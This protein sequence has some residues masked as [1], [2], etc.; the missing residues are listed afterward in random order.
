MELSLFYFC[1]TEEVFAFSSETKQLLMFMGPRP[2]ANRDHLIAFL[3]NGSLDY[4]GD[5]MFHGIKQ[6]LG[7]CSLLLDH[8]TE[9]SHITRWYHLDNTPTKM[10]RSQKEDNLKFA[11]CFKQ[12][13]RLDGQGAD[14]HLGGYTVFYS[15]LFASLIRNGR[16]ISFW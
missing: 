6:L 12:S 14:E 3:T 2:E 10:K 9:E 5:T 8:G 7:G 1:D 13:V 11:D 16:F 4:S 15:V